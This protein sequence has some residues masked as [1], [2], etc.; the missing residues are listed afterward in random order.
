VVLVGHSLGSVVTYDVLNG[1]INEDELHRT[2]TGPPQRVAERTRMLL[3]FGSPLDKTAFLFA[4][5][6]HRLKEG[7][8]ALATTVQ[9]LIQDYAFRHLRWV[10]I[11]SPW[12]IISGALNYYDTHNKPVPPGVDNR[13]DPEATT[14]LAA[15]VEYWTNP[16]LRN[17]LV[18]ELTT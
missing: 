16:L 6:T 5:Q 17:I 3:T 13:A 2:S 12:D 18:A 10:N 4:S 1:L 8:E 15:H 11:Y 7:R 14:L 9:P